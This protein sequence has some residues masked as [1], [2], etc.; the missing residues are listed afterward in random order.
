[1]ANPK[2][3][4]GKPSPNRGGQK[5]PVYSSAARPSTLF[6][7]LNKWFDGRA[8]ILTIV[9]LS[10][11][12]LFSLL[13][14]QARMDIGG[15]DSAYLERAFNFVHKGEFPIFQGPLYPLVLSMFVAPFGINIVLLKFLSIVFNI[16]GLWFF[17]KAF[18]KRLPSFVFYPVFFIAAINSYI[19]NFASLTYNEAFFTMLQYIFFFIFFKLIDSGETTDLAGNIKESFKLWLPSGLLIFMLILTRN[20]AFVCLGGLVLYLVINKQYKHVLYLVGAFL[21]FQLPMMALEK[22]VFHVQNQWQS[23][24]ELLLLK[25]P[26]N[27][28][29][30]YENFSGFVNRFF[31]NCGIYLSKRFMQI[32]G[33]RSADSTDSIG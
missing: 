22:T 15:D 28:A 16:V 4:K 3:I 18:Y 30:G 26:Y 1:M 27:K 25:N 32:I 24:G 12:F 14:F 31:E 19:L 7:R 33:F 20:I 29:E 21:V 8:N 17:Y 9:I 23:Q 10:L 13:L 6:E 2:N 5:T 11:S